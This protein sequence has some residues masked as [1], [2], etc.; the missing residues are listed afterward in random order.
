MTKLISISIQLAAIFTLTASAP[1]VESSGE[2]IVTTRHQIK[3][4][5]KIL[6]YTARAGLAPIRRNE[7]GEIHG[8][9]F[10]IFL[11]A[12][13]S[14]HKR[15]VLG[16]GECAAPFACNTL[17]SRKTLVAYYADGCSPVDKGEIGPGL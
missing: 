9:I 15:F 1:A 7:T 8:H 3:V 2:R 6:R 16:G 11:C 12:E 10:F 13:Y 14:T 17:V 4:G 5:Q